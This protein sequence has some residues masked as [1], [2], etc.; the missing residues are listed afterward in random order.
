MM[1]ETFYANQLPSGKTQRKL[2]KSLKGSTKSPKKYA[3]SIRDGKHTDS[4]CRAQ[5]HKTTLL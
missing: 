3:K 4:E 2:E 5:K 1:T